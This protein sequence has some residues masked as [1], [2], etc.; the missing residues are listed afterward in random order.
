MGKWWSDLWDSIM[1]CDP[2]KV[3]AT[4]R[5]RGGEEV[6]VTGFFHAGTYGVASESRYAREKAEKGMHFYVSRSNFDELQFPS[7]TR[8]QLWLDEDT[9]YTIVS[10]SGEGSGML[11]LDL[12]ETR[13]A[14][15][16]T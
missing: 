15:S 16:R 13:N 3:R 9:Y 10:V 1:D 8:G 11:K 5:L 6:E 12:K 2:E 7:I 14:A 4:V